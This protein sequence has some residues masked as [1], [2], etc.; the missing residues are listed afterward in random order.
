VNHDALSAALDALWGGAQDG[1]QASAD[2]E[3][4]LSAALAS[5]GPS[6]A[7]VVLSRW[8][9]ERARTRNQVSVVATGLS[10]LGGGTRSV[11]QTLIAL[12]GESSQ[13][14]LVTAYSLTSGSGRVI[15]AIAASASAGVRCVF[16]INRLDQQRID[17][18]T[19]LADLVSLHP[20][21]V[22]VHSFADTATEGLH[23]K[24]VVVD[25]RVALVGSANLTF[26]GMTASHELGLLVRGPAAGAV[27][28]AIDLLIASPQVHV[29]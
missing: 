28:S 6:G 11:E 9:T 14:I 4:A 3:E 27:A 24:V 10:W 8:V 20:G 7:A 5:A 2:L 17:V 13:E 15:D 26:H 19:R 22:V 21:R 12:I 18:Q 25:R 23:A 1:A 16:V 29:M